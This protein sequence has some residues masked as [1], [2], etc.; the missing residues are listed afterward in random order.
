MKFF[1]LFLNQDSITNFFHAIVSLM[2][3]H[4]PA[5]L[6]GGFR[7]LGTLFQDSNF[8]RFDFLEKQIQSYLVNFQTYK[9]FDRKL[10]FQYDFRIFFDKIIVRAEI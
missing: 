7:C 9:E 10:Q 5:S 1:P 4:I 3:N 8:G 2:G 6:S